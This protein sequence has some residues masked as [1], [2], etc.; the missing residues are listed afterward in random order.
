MNKIFLFNVRSSIIFQKVGLS[1]LFFDF[2][3]TFYVGSGFKSGFGSTRLLGKICA[4]LLVTAR[5]FNLLQ[6]TVFAYENLPD[7]RGT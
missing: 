4:K 3:M 7:I 6:D 5:K 1:F 2:L